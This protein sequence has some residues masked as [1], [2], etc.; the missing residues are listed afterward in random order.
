M[1]VKIIPLE[2]IEFEG[3]KISLG[4]PMDD[5][6]K[7]L[8]V[9][10]DVEQTYSKGGIPDG[11]SVYCF[12]NELRFDLDD[13]RLEFIEFL[14]GPEGDLQPE[15]YGVPAFGTDADELVELLTEKNGEDIIDDEDGYS[16]AFPSIGI[17]V[18][19]ESTPEDVKGLS[20]E[21]E[22]DGDPLGIGAYE[23]ELAKA[24][25]WMTIG[26]GGSDYYSG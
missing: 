20:D 8:G 11:T 5:M 1:Q 14:G 12:D 24:S 13:D 15:I 26:L 2:G 3:R 6:I 25:R 4:M 19:R 22:E 17:G 7:A 10:C 18:Y 23:S 16:Y 21:A 9:P